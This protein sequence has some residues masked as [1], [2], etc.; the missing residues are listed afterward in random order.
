[1]DDSGQG[2]ALPP[3]RCASGGAAISAD[4]TPDQLSLGRPML[5]GTTHPATH[6]FRTSTKNDAILE[7][8][9]QSCQRN[10]FECSC[11]VRMSGLSKIEM[12]AFMGR[13]AHGNGAYRLEPARTRATESAA[14]GKAEAF[15]AGGGR[16]AAEDH[17]PSGPAN[18]FGAREARRSCRGAWTARPSI[19]SQAGCFIRAEDSGPG[20]AAVRGLWADSG[21]RTFSQGRIGGEPRDP[22]EVDD[23]GPFVASPL[24]AREGHPCVARTAGLFWRD[25]DA[26]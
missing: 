6:G 16:R 13:G 24:A 1:M 8:R 14:R 3:N 17:G 11:K 22:A 7:H 15:D 4:V 25:G 23:P 12:S 18:S 19:E 26:G 9:I 5:L 2:L 10:V 20:T 21:C